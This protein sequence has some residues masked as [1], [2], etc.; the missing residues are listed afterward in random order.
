MLSPRETE[1][2]EL[3]AEGQTSKQIA[4]TLII[5]EK[6]VDRH[7][8]NMLEKLGLH[9]RVELVRFAIRNGLVEP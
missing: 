1:V 4:A 6:T 9:D 2:L 5:S 3:V 8:T 7:R